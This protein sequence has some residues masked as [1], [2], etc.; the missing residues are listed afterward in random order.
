MGLHV[1][2]A[3][4]VEDRR[5]DKR[6]A[7]MRRTDLIPYQLPGERSAEIGGK[8]QRGVLINRAKHILAPVRAQKAHGLGL[9]PA[10]ATGR[11]EAAGKTRQIEHLHLHRRRPEVAVMAAEEQTMEPS[12]V[13]AGARHGC[14]G[15]WVREILY[16]LAGRAERRTRGGQDDAALEYRS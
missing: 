14:T 10:A 6:P 8:R 16:R 13:V 1:H 12:R 11:R 3:G 4:R 15:R 2:D 7:R 9:A 5:D